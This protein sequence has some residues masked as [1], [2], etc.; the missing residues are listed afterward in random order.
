MELD[1]YPGGRESGGQK[2]ALVEGHQPVERPVH[3]QKGGR[4]SI[5]VGDRI[6]PAYLIRV[7]LDRTTDQLRFWRIRHIMDLTVRQS[8][9]IHLEKIRGPI[10]IAH[11]LYAT[12]VI[13]V[14]SNIKVAD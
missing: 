13:E 1:R 11:G 3:D 14:F 6:R 9:R 7:I 8:M 4:A 2:L 12:R 10:E 5:D